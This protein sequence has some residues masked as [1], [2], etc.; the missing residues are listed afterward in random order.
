MAVSKVESR[1][2]VHLNDPKDSRHFGTFVVQ[3]PIGV[4]S[5]RDLADDMARES[6]EE[7]FSDFL[8]DADSGYTLSVHPSQHSSQPEGVHRKSSNGCEAWFTW[9]VGSMSMRFY[10]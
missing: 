9:G 3:L 2:E 5:H 4:A 1:R 10:Y 7:V 6:V 8:S